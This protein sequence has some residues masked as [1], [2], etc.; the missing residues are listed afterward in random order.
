MVIV[1]VPERHAPQPERCLDN[2]PWTDLDGRSEPTRFLELTTATATRLRNGSMHIARNTTT[3]SRVRCG[4]AGAWSC[5]SGMNRRRVPPTPVDLLRLAEVIAVAPMEADARAG[6]HGVSARGRRRGRRRG[7]RTGATGSARPIE[8]ARYRLER[9]AASPEHGA[10]GAVRRTDRVL[11]R[12]RLIV[13]RS[14]RATRRKSSGSHP[15][16]SKRGG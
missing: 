12:G 15:V 6:E 14:V 9:S 7:G 2:G 1:D 3:A 10:L 5:R 11:W 13:P 8:V 4:R 16:A